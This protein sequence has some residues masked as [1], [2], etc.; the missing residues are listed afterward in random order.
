MDEDPALRLPR[1]EGEKKISTAGPRKRRG[2]S[3][4]SKEVWAKKI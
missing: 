2:E 4:I 3:F 1:R